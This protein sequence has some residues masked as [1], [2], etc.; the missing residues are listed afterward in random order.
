MGGVIVAA[1]H[2]NSAVACRGGIRLHLDPKFKVAE[3]LIRDKPD[4]IVFAVGWDLGGDGAIDNFPVMTLI[5]VLRFT[6]DGPAVKRGAIKEGNF[7]GIACG[8]R[9]I[10]VV[11]ESQRK[12]ASEPPR[13]CQN[14]W[15]KQESAISWHFSSPYNGW[16]EREWDVCL[17]PSG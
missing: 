1:P 13:H 8:R 10:L 9:S 2:L 4:V 11:G 5:F 3:F 15:I 16:N 14:G 17:Q 7:S 6:L 12:A